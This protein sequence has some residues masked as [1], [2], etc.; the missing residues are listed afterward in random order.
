MLPFACASRNSVSLQL[1]S[2]RGKVGVR[3][4][5]GFCM[6]PDAAQ[7]GQQAHRSVRIGVEVD[8]YINFALQQNDVPVVKAIRVENPLEAPFN[9]VR[10]EIFAEPDFACVWTRHLD[11]LP[12]SADLVFRDI[13]LVLRPGYLSNLSERLRGLLHVRLMQG[14]GVLA[15]QIV[16]IELLAYDEWS[17]LRSLPEIAAAFV[18]PNHP[19]VESALYTA[20]EFLRSTTGDSSLS[21]YQTQS[22]ER[23]LRTT[24]AIYVALSSLGVRYASPPASFE[25]SGQK[26]RTPD[27]IAESKL[28]TCLD[29]ATFA[30]ACLEQAGLHP[31]L[32]FTTGHAFVGVWLDEE[33]FPN[34]TEDELLKL[35]KRVEL[36][37]IC[38]FE[39]THITGTP[40]P[41]FSRAVADGNRHLEVFDD[42]HC[43]VDIKRARKS[44]IRPLP[45]RTEGE[46][47]V[48]VEELP[49][50][51]MT[52][53]GPSA[54][55]V[56]ERMSETPNIE[57]PKSRLDSWRRKLL[58]LTLHNR[59]LNHKDSRKSLPLISYDL[60]GLEDGLAGGAIFQLRARPG[61]FSAADPRDADA[62]RRRTGDEGLKSLISEEFKSKRL[63]GD[64]TPEELERRLIEL[65]RAA[66]ISIEE[67]GASALY[68]TVGFLRWYET[69]KSE[70]PLLAPLLLVPVELERKSIQH[71]FRLLRGAD[72]T[73]VNTTLLERLRSDFGLNIAGLEPLPYD[74]SGVDVGAVLRI[75]RGAVKDI[76][77]WEVL[78]AT[79]L[80][81]FSFAKFLMWRD[82]QERAEELMNS[83]VV[84]HLV[85]KDGSR[86]D[87]D[88]ITRQPDHL[89]DSV[90]PK[91]CFTPLD[92]DS[93]QLW[94]VVCAAR[95]KSF[96]LWGPPGTGKSQTITNMISHALASGKT[97][98]FVSEK[99]AALNVVFSRL[100]KLG[101]ERFCLELHSNKTRKHGVIQQLAEVLNVVAEAPRDDWERK[102]DQL[103]QIRNRL[104]ALVDALHRRRRNGLSVFV[105]TSK[106]IGLKNAPRVTI[107]WSNPEEHSQ[108]TLD[109][110]RE[111]VEVLA[112]LA[113][114]VGPLEANPWTSLKCREWS[115]QWQETLQDKIH[116]ALQSAS[117]LRSSTVESAALLGLEHSDWPLRRF[118]IL[119][120]LI[121]RVLICPALPS[122]ILTEESWCQM[123]SDIGEWTKIG[124]ER[125]DIQLLVNRRFNKQVSNLD[126]VSMLSDWKNIVN[127]LPVCELPRDF[128]GLIEKLEDWLS[129][130]QKRNKLRE[131]VFSVLVEDVMLID[132]GQLCGYWQKVRSSGVL[133]RWWV[134]RRA[135]KAIR[136]VLR[137]QVI[138]DSVILS[139]IDELE[140]LNQ[141]EV[142][143]KKVG[144]E[145]S[146]VLGRLW[147][148]G[149]PEIEGLQGAL[150]WAQLAGAMLTKLNSFTSDEKISAQEV[151]LWL[152]RLAILEVCHDKMGAVH[153]RARDLFGAYWRDGKPNWEDITN[154]VRWAD[155]VRRCATDIADGEPTVA[156]AIRGMIA[157]LL[158]ECRSELGQGGSVRFTLERCSQNW[159]DFQEI[160]SV[161]LQVINL[162]SQELPIDSES[163][164]YLADFVQLMERWAGANVHLR[165]WCDWNAGRDD[166][167]RLG[168]QAIVQE[169]EQ[170]KIRPE[171]FADVFHRSYYTWWLTRTVDG[172]ELLRRFSSA[173]HDRL[174][175][176]FREIDGE[177][178]KLTREL[179]LAR[180]AEKI[181]TVTKSVMPSSEMGILQNEIR[182]KTRHI[183][184][185]S[186]VGKLPTLMPRLKPCF[187][188]SP[189]SVAQYLD[190]S[191]PPFDIVVFD[192]ASQIPVWDAVGALA[193]GRQAIVVGDPK[194]LPPTNFFSRADE[195]PEDVE[196][197]LQDLESVLDDCLGAQMPQLH[198]D[199]HYRSRHESLIHFSNYHY[200]ENRLLIFPS[201][202][203]DG[204][205]VRWRYVP[206][207][208]YGRSKDRTNRPEAERVVEEVVSRLK[209][210]ERQK[211]SIGVVTF[212]V[213]QQG[214]VEELLDVARR[215]HPEIERFMSE[216]EAEE[217][218]FVK[219]LENVQG[220]ERDVIIFSICYGPD[221][222]GVV[223]LNFGP[224]NRLGGER[225]LNVAITRARSELIVFTSLRAD[226]INLAR[227]KATG[228][229]H[230]KTF[231]DYAER[232]A[233]ALPS[234]ASV[235]DSNE[236]ESPLEQEI[237][238]ALVGKG[239]QLHKQVGCSGYRIDLAVVH[240]EYQ[241]RYVIA[242]ECDGANYHRAKSARDRDRLRESVLR[243]LGWKLVRVWSTDWW[244]NSE[245]ELDKLDRAIRGALD[246]YVRDL[247][248]TEGAQPQ[249]DV[250][251][252]GSE[253]ARGEQQSILDTPTSVTFKADAD[254]S[255]NQHARYIPFKVMRCAG[256]Q[257]DFSLP[258][259]RNKI[260]TVLCE[261]VRAEGPVSFSTACRRVAAHWGF[262]KA[263]GRVQELVRGLVQGGELQLLESGG[264]E[265]LWPAEMDPKEYRE[266]RVNGPERDSS[267]TV[268]EIPL[269]EI[270]NAILYILHTNFGMPSSDLR[271]SAARIFGFSR[272]GSAV[273]GRIDSALSR[274]IVEGRV[275]EREGTVSISTN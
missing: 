95:G 240:P 152:E 6:E 217:P 161:L 210:P 5:R 109:G 64:V 126:T 77:R 124:R 65:Y 242:I 238:D 218:V 193:R 247:C 100:K 267:R 20:S 255:S 134:R 264:I 189:M 225:R 187:L 171:Q 250:E 212:S 73:R 173:E 155:S 248:Q 85:Q 39:T 230:L 244:S 227:T 133:T 22:R 35:R 254:S 16:P 75:F 74:E 207:G 231:L 249:P 122:A 25:L 69:S 149:E 76:D 159:R 43:L 184:V 29:L 115:N 2:S 209:D 274:L 179:V 80:G 175:E 117:S 94:S 204:M 112:V 136:P 181:P 253:V 160:Q 201:P 8:S 66:R 26:V 177:F 118:P 121:D 19:A 81:F 195:E 142:L 196:D 145:A 138:A 183:S 70:K 271:T 224:I 71:G 215:E 141:S 101:L 208:V 137:S 275:L 147:K 146:L 151:L 216:D 105:A 194:Q 67:G 170:G 128:V 79:A 33:C 18:F 135:R 223:S 162:T 59:L 68:L 24:E 164:T 13:D 266:F 98:L 272:T 143:A 197:T 167:V 47:T 116:S 153:E 123:T 148:D 58:D 245:R 233:V 130:I 232:G 89:D 60:S 140:Q 119:S 226:M 36:G 111:Q 256:S 190:P 32:V 202:V 103:A 14:E 99:S 174:I 156:S 186:L 273:A 157:S 51:G 34:S 199:W 1:R 258:G 82:L 30:A 246:S 37:E 182:K 97:V 102:S 88:F 191:F 92:A 241:G 176:K 259:S 150:K 91:D 56:I 61:E 28:G 213:A 120:K 219:N 172:E 165:E 243:D 228:S 63:C 3:P 83:P 263:T 180:L 234:S 93:S 17:G 45:L 166:S 9:D 269:E 96:V 11:T 262:L 54:L 158:F 203:P 27:R 57:T 178:L 192:E 72:E 84:R 129:L 205:G 265:F 270:G 52:L 185:R 108:D 214:L 222:N 53:L 110:L 12:A 268:D 229:A 42:F 104:N 10:M 144:E 55:N 7:G 251:C 198:L 163:S 114:R 4:N 44:S 139:T 168:L 169:Y 257:V 90:G 260:F 237:H 132:L 49:S 40:S 127:T 188:M 41:D 131:S 23:V 21:G 113:R 235:Q 211:S 38:V 125:D 200:Y 106:L 261:V 46:R 252:N 221:H 15:S 86:F 31:M 78:D 206:E 107:T 239:W 87:P 62:F 154:A 50:D 220:D 48:I 236:C